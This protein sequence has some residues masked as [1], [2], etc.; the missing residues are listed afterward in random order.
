MKV[1]YVY[2]GKMRD[3]G[4]DAVAAQQI[5]ALSEAGIETVLISR[6][7]VD[8]PHVL[9]RRVWLNPAK[10][11]SWRPAADYYGA[12]RRFI[13]WMAARRLRR[14]PF[15]MVAAWSKGGLHA[16]RAAWE[17]GI[18][19]LVTSGSAAAYPQVSPDEAFP[20]P[21]ISL[22]EMR[23]E[24]ECA[25]RVLAPSDL[26]VRRYVEEGVDALKVVP[27]YRGC[28]LDR[29]YPA[30][31][32]PD[33]FRVFFCG[34]VCE[35]KGARQVLD[36]WEKAGL[37]D[38]E[39]WFAGSID[40]ELQTWAEAAERPGIRFLGFQS[41]VAGLMRQCSAQILLSRNEGFVK[42]LVEGAACGLAT[43]GTPRVGFPILEGQTGFV[44]DRDDTGQVARLFRRLY[45]NRQECRAIG[46]A[47][48][49]HV[50]GLFT[51]A[52]FRKRFLAIVQ[53]AAKTAGN[54]D[55]V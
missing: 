10:L 49:N 16:L 2:D 15:D 42:S 51:W 30:E 38:A 36:A 6:G 22:D 13:S 54:R 48:H 37:T 20:W 23:E 44:A 40:K 11:L 50:K 7:R 1:L 52:H 8:L 32:H 14:E 34:R 33:I 31:A 25:T 17:R 28:D 4:L 26:A 45:E 12:N 41:D 35:R 9:N 39:L 19:S 24:Y 55:G 18:P 29:F 21:R 5:Q 53:D 47:A 27:I 3:H 46:L 43:I